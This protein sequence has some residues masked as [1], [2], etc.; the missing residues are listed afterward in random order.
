[1]EKKYLGR[2]LDTYS[3]SVLI[4]VKENKVFVNKTKLAE[5]PI[6]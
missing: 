1:M 3:F 4:S 6:E 2:I 5:L